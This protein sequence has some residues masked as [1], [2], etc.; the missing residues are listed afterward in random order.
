MRPFFT[1]FKGLGALLILLGFA[2]ASGFF[3]WESRPQAATIPFMEKPAMLA[4]GT[5]SFPVRLRIPALHVNAPVE[6]VGLDAQRNM[7]APSAWNDV[8]WYDL[9]PRPGAAG[10]AVIAGHYDSYTGAAVFVSLK[11]LKPGDDVY[12]EDAAGMQHRFRVTRSELYQTDA[13]P[14]NRIFGPATGAHLNLLTCGGAWDSK[15]GH[16]TERLAVF[17]EAVANGA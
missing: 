11:K 4:S 8:G 2:A 13:A 7:A 9:G 17:T 12:V 14:M 1:P 6:D 10:N 5:G 3:A 15:H 16:Y